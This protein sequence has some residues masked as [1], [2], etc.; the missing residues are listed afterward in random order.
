VIRALGDREPEVMVEAKG[1]EHTPVGVE[2][3]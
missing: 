3:G 2:I 1:K